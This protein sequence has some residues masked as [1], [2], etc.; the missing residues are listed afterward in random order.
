MEFHNAFQQLLQI[1]NDQTVDELTKWREFCFSQ[2]VEIKMKELETKR[3]LSKK[4]KN[5]ENGSSELVDLH[6]E[7]LNK[8]NQE[9]SLKQQKENLEKE[10]DQIVLKFS[11]IK[12][13]IQTIKSKQTQIKYIPQMFSQRK[14]LFEEQIRQ[15]T[16]EIYPFSRKIDDLNAKLSNLLKKVGSIHAE[17]ININDDMTFEQ[18]KLELDNVALQLSI[19]IEDMKEDPINDNI[20]V[21][22]QE[23]KTLDD[24]KNALALAQNEVNELQRNIQKY[25]KGIVHCTDEIDNIINLMKKEEKAHIERK[26][27]LDEQYDVEFLEEETKESQKLISE[28]EEKLKEIE[29]NYSQLDEEMKQAVIQLTEEE[30]QNKLEI[31]DLKNQLASLYVPHQCKEPVDIGI[32]TVIGY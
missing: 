24:A 13:E 31:E 12:Q 27:Q 17:K 6:T 25:E 22:A 32:R 16:T 5:K 9:E 7:L 21:L 2:L 29:E 18:K 28:Y 8:T 11:A 10:N 1:E 30:E 3:I 20:G 14:N 23:Y 15:I 26:I 19:S 4:N